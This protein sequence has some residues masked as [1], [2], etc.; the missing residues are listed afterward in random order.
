[1]AGETPVSL[2][3]PGFSS[4]SPLP[5]RV[6][7]PRISACCAGPPHPSSPSLSTP[8]RARHTPAFARAASLTDARSVPRPALGSVTRVDSSPLLSRSLGSSGVP[9]YA[10]SPN[11]QPSSCCLWPP[12][13]LRGFLCWNVLL[14]PV[15]GQFRLFSDLSYFRNLSFSLQPCPTPTPSPPKV[16]LLTQAPRASSTSPRSKDH[17]SV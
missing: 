10:S 16:L 9:G 5:E 14:P 12:A 1:M 15:C 3:L 17:A 11:S 13:R 6:R 2:V 8:H 7:A 4:P